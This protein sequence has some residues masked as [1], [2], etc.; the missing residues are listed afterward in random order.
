M[1]K[2]LVREVVANQLNTQTNIANVPQTSV[3]SINVPSVDS[4][5]P[6]PAYNVH[7]RLQPHPQQLQQHAQQLQQ[8]SSVDSHVQMS[9]AH[10]LLVAATHTSGMALPSSPRETTAPRMSLSHP[11]LTRLQNFS[12]APTSAPQVQQHQQQQQNAKM[13]PLLAAQQTQMMPNLETSVYEQVIH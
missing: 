7:Q 10:P 2:Q 8:K 3:P 13:H 5:L 6:P 1:V 4:Y 12:F 9:P 11:D